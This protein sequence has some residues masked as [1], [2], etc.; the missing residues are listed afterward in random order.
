MSVL[1][2]H[3]KEIIQ[4]FRL[5]HN[6]TNYELDHAKETDENNLPPAYD[7]YYYDDMPFYNLSM[8]G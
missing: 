7:L 3:Y 8:Y 2:M 6:I 5:E 4:S 1:G